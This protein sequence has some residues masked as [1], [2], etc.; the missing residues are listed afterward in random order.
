MRQFVE[1]KKF[2]YWKQR[3]THKHPQHPPPAPQQK[4]RERNL[5]GYGIPPSPPPPLPC[6]ANAGRGAASPSTPPPSLLSTSSPLLPLPGSRGEGS[7]RVW[8][9][10]PPAWGGVGGRR[11]RGARSDARS[12]LRAPSRTGAAG[13]GHGA[14]G[15]GRAR[16]GPGARRGAVAP[17]PFPTPGFS[18]WGVCPG[19]ARGRGESLLVWTPPHPRHRPVCLSWEL[20]GLPSSGLCAT[21][22]SAVVKGEASLA[23]V[24]T[25][26]FAA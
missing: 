13:S 25:G 20:L 4:R 24:L 22:H 10:D 12:V 9:G 17:S 3:R 18:I 1:Q 21:S 6:P 8:G 5:T 26:H 11:V 16:G 2:G 23:P 15:G 19:R 7:G 14:E